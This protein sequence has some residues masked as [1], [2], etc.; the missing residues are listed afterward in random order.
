MIFSGVKSL[1]AA[2]AIVAAA[3]E[4]NLKVLVDALHWMRAGDTLE[5]LRA[6]GSL[7]YAQ[8][9]DGPL[10]SPEGREALIAEARTSRLA[11]GDGRFPL[12]A[13]LDAMPASCVAS[14]EVPLPSG[15]DPRAHARRLREAARKLVDQKAVTG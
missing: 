5:A 13:L 14:V 3:G 8:L 15:L 4:P 6:A 10:E 1:K 12:R 2:L 9:C 7:G 11:P